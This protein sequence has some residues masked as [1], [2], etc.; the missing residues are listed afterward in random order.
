MIAQSA[1]P[2]SQGVTRAFNGLFSDTRAHHFPELFRYIAHKR[3][4]WRMERNGGRWRE[5][6]PFQCLFF[7]ISLVPFFFCFTRCIRYPSIFISCPLPFNSFCFYC[8]CGSFVLII[9]FQS[10]P[11]PPPTNPTKEIQHSKNKIK[12]NKLSR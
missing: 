3:E 6:K 7:I 8:C 12:C 2:Y 1:Q 9:R 4:K 5:R 10:R 11:P